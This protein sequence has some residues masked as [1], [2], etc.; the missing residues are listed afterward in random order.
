MEREKEKLGLV[1]LIAIVI[2]GIIGGGIFNISKILAE[3]ASLGA[4]IISWGI[5]GIG[6]S[7][8]AMTFKTLN[9]VRP[10]LSKGIYK[11]ART[12]FGDYAGFNVAW[13]YWMGTAIGNVVFSVMLN[14]AFGL[15]FPI[16]LKHSWP[17]LIFASCFS[18]FFTLLVSFGLKLAT[19]IN[20]IS[21]IIKFSSLA[22]IIIL[23]FSFA[24]Y[25]LLH[26]DFWGKASHL[27]PLSKQINSTM[28]TTLFF[29]MG[30]EGAV[31]VASKARIPSDVG[32]AT[33]IGYLI[34]LILNIM[35]C[36][37]S[38]GF[39]D[40]AEMVKLNDPALAQILGKGVGE[41]ARIFVNVSV[42]IAVAGAW[43]VSTIIAAELPAT[44]ATDRVLPHFFARR[45]KRE[46]PI[47]ALLITAC[48]IQLFLV[49][50]LQLKN[51]YV[52][53]VDISGIMILPTYILSAMFLIK[54]TLKKRIHINTPITR[55]V[56]IISGTV[57]ALYCFWVI[58]AGNVHL[59]LLS[60]VVY[61]IGIFFYWLTQH[62]HLPSRTK[63]FTNTDR[64]VVG[65]LIVAMIFALLLEWEH[66]TIG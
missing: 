61:V 45:N 11:Y 31:I 64:Y 27:G 39:I 36:I 60:S 29:F 37:L 26:I 33:I 6:L 25:N 34:C 53:S 38:F 2:G 17:T 5:S 7:G 46:A 40:Q 50:I 48:F 63:L 54:S 43:L 30:I 56:S 10:D 12:G 52:L 55:Q 4:I 62:N 57:T 35:V 44:A 22:L 28:L 58:Y 18:W 15:F 42:I 47:N 23:L 24:N 16:L 65:L 19:A 3:G 1:G 21:T 8:I 20:T 41:W 14:D 13:G 66:Q 32:K 51:I 49:L 59:L 9:E